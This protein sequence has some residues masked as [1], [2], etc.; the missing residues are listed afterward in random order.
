MS[1]FDTETLLE[2]G[3]ILELCRKDGM[4]LA[5]A[6]SCTGGLIAACLTEIAGS[7]D[8]FDCGFVTYSNFAKQELL[9]VNYDTLAAFGAVSKQTALEMARGALMHSHALLSVAVTG[10]AGPGG[11]TAEK[12]VGLVY[13][14]AIRK[15]RE[16]ICHEFQFSGL[17][18]AMVRQAALRQALTML[19]RLLA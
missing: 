18:R 17:S 11:G 16:P 19:L 10:I 4:K 6:E 8:V 5:A 7:S 13:I 14:A 12:P 3:R 9:G 2:A 15:G 1:L